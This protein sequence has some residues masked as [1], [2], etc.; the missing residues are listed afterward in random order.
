MSESEKAKHRLRDA[1]GRAAAIRAAVHAEWARHP[2]GC[3][4]VVC[5]A[6]A[7]D[8]ASFEEVAIHYE[9]HGRVP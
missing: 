2:L 9:E 6:E 7:G 4:C 8:E 5:K 3:E 1:L